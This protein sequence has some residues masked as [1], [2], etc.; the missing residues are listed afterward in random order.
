[1]LGVL[2]IRSRESIN[3]EAVMSMK[4]ILN[5]VKFL[6]SKTYGVGD[7]LPKSHVLSELDSLDVYKSKKLIHILSEFSDS[8]VTRLDVLSDKQKASA[9]QF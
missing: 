3:R 8:T 5:L 1:M 7:T 2:P 9:N 6:S 4:V